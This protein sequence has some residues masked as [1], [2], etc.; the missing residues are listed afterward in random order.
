MVRNIAVLLSALVLFACAGG[1]TL[2]EQQP[3]LPNLSEGK[4]RIFF[5]RVKR[6]A[7]SGIQPSVFLNGKK[8]GTAVP[9]GVFYRDVLAGNYLVNITTEVRKQF[10][11]EI[12]TGQ[13]RYIKM[14]MGIG[15]LFARVTP[16][17]VLEQEAMPQIMRLSLMQ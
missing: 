3:Q 16:I 9:G 14:I 15:W 4:G 8:V 17:L 1:P 12:K 11:F 6:F 10:N 13:T 7:G 5:F 2:R